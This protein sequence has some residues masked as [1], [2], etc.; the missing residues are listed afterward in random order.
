MTTGEDFE[1]LRRL[2]DTYGG[3]RTRWPAQ[4]RL[5]FA[6]LVSTSSK[7]Q[8]MLA[9]ASALDRLLSMAPADVPVRDVERLTQRIVARA[10]AEVPVV[11]PSAGLTPVQRGGNIT[12][13]PQRRAPAAAREYWPQAAL[14]AAC[15]MLGI[16]AGQTVLYG[17]M[18]EPSEIVTASSDSEPDATELALDGLSAEDL[19]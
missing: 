17:T 8:A 7:A 13:L 18:M 10:K 2:L 6:G 12:P 11:A 16:F 19:L 15:L 4:D 9:E 3:D 5:R 1:A 14:L